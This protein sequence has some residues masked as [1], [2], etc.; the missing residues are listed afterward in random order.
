MPTIPHCDAGLRT[1]PPVSVP[2][3]AGKNPAA[4][5]EPDPL[6]DPPGW[7]VRFHGLRAGGQGRSS[8]GPPMANS[9]VESLPLSTPPAARRR[10]ATVASRLAAVSPQILASRVVGTPPPS[11]LSLRPP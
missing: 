10:R 3:A 6:D 9:C 11:P 4:R 5:P 1:D 2:I 7:Q 8:D